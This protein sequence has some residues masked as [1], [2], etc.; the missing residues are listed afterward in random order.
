MAARFNAD[1]V[2]DVAQQRFVLFVGSGASKWAQPNG[3]GNFKDWIGFLK[4]A[5]KKLKKNSKPQKI[6]DSLINQQDY[7]LA[8]E[9]LKKNLDTGWESLLT[10]EFQQA[11]DI[12]RLHKAL[13]G[14]KPRIIVTTNF[15]KLI[16][17]AWGLGSHDRYPTVISKIDSEAFK[18]FRSE[19]NYLIKLHG[20]IDEPKGIVFDKT[21]Y[22]SGAF[23]N[24]YYSEILSVLLL[25]HT[26]IFIGFS[27]TDPAV[28]LVVEN[29]AYRYKSTRP[30][31]I[32]QAGTPVAE[33]D[34][35]WRQFRK[36]Y[37]LRYPDVNKHE[38]LATK[39]EQLAVEAARRRIEIIASRVG[40]N[41]I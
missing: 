39:L 31:Y 37:V 1:L 33:V 30:H 3:G 22:Q 10:Q 8:S 26:F 23:G 35:M 7:L 5:N 18:L 38:A 11:A 29:A 36:L 15:D 20:S 27:M 34:E 4:E 6:V 14:L 2:D 21:S 40:K 41:A 28:S 25:T 13:I 9:V 24:P 16:E 12:S 17:G 19:E 32:F